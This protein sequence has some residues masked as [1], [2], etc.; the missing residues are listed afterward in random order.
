MYPKA[1]NTTQK[2]RFCKRV[3]YLSGTALLDKIHRYEKH[4][5]WFG[6]GPLLTFIRY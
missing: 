6:Y 3:Q 1:K 2:L 4:L 5:C